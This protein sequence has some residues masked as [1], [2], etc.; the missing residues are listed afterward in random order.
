MTVVHARLVAIGA[1]TAL[2]ALASCGGKSTPKTTTATAASRPTAAELRWRRQVRLFAAALV[3]Q[4]EQVQGATGGG[5]KAGPIGP[6]I[7]ERVFVTGPRRRSFLSALTALEGCRGSLDRQVPRAP[8]PG[9]VPVRTALADA[10]AA[11]ASAGRS[12]RRAV[13]SAGPD[14]AVDPGVLAFARGQARDGVRLV[15]DALALLARAPAG[16]G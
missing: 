13:A 8:A 14:R 12:L 1:A 15:V 2:L 10:C 9:L 6:R 4:L 3:G 5:P 11:L 7:E 16:S